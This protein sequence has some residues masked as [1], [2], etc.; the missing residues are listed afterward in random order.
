VSDGTLR[1]ELGVLRAALNYEH[2]HGRLLRVPHVWLPSKPAGK[3]RW[4]ERDEAAR[5]LWASR[6]DSKARQY[7][8][9]FI[10]I[11]LYTGARKGAILDMRWPQVD[12]ARGVIDFNPPGRKRTDKGRSI[13]PI[14]RGLKWFL[15]KAR[16]RG[17]DLGYVISRNGKPLGDIKKGFAAAAI[18]AGLDE[19]TPHTLRHTAGT[20]LAQKGVDLFQI[21]GWLGHSHD[22]TSELY[23]HHHP[24]HF[25]AAREAMD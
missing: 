24:D 7:L 16:E 9:L 3:D 6:H 5:L 2:K 15:V 13:I 11:G 20:W 22:R 25:K 23:A 8:P 19:V 12:F 4:L 17:S 21:A 10:L 14:P 18:R 1:R